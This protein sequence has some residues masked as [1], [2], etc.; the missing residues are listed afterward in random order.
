MCEVP[1]SNAHFVHTVV[2]LMP[3]GPFTVSDIVMLPN[4]YAV[5]ARAWNFLN[6]N[7]YFGTRTSAAVRFRFSFKR[8]EQ[9]DG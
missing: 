8:F 9:H 4:C 7:L 2:L 5:M 3:S 1:S 6:G